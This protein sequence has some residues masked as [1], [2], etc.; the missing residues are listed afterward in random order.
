MTLKIDGWP[1]KTIGHLFYAASSYVHHFIAINIFKL[2]LQSGNA[3][4]G[5]ISV[6]FVLCDLQVWWMTLKN[7]REPLLYYFKLCLSF[8][9]HLWI[10]TWVTVRK[11]SIR[12]KISDFLSH[13][14]LKIDGWPWKTIG[15]LFYAASSY[16]HHFIAINIFKLELQSG[17]AQFGSISVIFVLCDLQVWWMTLKNNREPLLYYFKLCLSFQSHLWIQTWVTVRK[18]SIRVKISDFL[19]HVTLKIDGWPWK[20][21]GHLFYAA[22]SYVH[23]FIAINIFKLEL[24]SGNAQ[25]GSISVIFVLCDLQVWWM[26]LKNN[27]EPLLYY[28]KLCL[29]F[30]SHLWIQ[31]WVTVRKRSIR[32]KI[33]DFLSHVTLKIDGWPWKTIGHLFYAASSYVHH[34][35]AINIFTLELQSGNAQFGSNQ[36]FFCPVWPWDLMND[37]EKQ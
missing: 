18:R 20:T 3:Q 11:R 16:V 23:H 29:S 33:S 32:V 17:N 31:T 25:F 2:E 36:W 10:Q 30:Q 15:H 28:F 12:V 5:S 13:V 34:F 26:T 14:T 24:Q 9:S 6:I 1:W 27:R 21:I 35:I 19:S 8:Q 22:S 4:F 7:N 37:L